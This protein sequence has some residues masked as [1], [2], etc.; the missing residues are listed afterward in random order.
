[1][2]ASLSIKITGC[3]PILMVKML[4]LTRLAIFSVNE[5]YDAFTCSLA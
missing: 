1:M 4:G 2:S 3:Y 5:M